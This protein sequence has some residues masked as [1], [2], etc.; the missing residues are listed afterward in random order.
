MT[1]R[2]QA[3]QRAVE[4]HHLLASLLAAVDDFEQAQVQTNLDHLHFGP[5]TSAREAGIQ[6]IGHPPVGAFCVSPLAFEACGR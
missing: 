5:R 6:L 2:A 4:Q 3:P 1:N